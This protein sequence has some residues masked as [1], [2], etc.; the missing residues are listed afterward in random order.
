MFFPMMFKTKPANGQRTSVIFVMCFTFRIAAFFARLTDEPS[1][2]NS[3][4]NDLIAAAL[5]GA[6]FSAVALVFQFSSLSFWI[7]VTLFFISPALY[8]ASRRIVSR[9]NVFLGAGNTLVQMPVPHSG[10]G[11]KQFDWF[12]S[13]A[14]ET[15]FCHASIWI[16]SKRLSIVKTV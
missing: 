10:V 14:F 7:L 3:I 2:P 15:N 8:S 4:I 1:I 16:E 12:S 9:G 5:A 11:I 13:F 6:T